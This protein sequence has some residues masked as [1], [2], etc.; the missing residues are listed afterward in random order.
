METLRR[1]KSARPKA[2]GKMV[3]N[4]RAIGQ[5]LKAEEP[6]SRIQ[7]PFSDLYGGR[8]AIIS[9]PYSP[10][11]LA[12]M[13]EVSD[14][15][16]QCISAMSTN[17]DGFGYELVKPEFLKEEAV[18]EAEAEEEKKRLEG[19]FDYCNPGENFTIL[20]QKL[21]VDLEA[22]GNGYIEVVRNRGGEVSE[23]Y[24]LP[25]YTVRMTQ[26]DKDWTPFTQRVMDSET[27]QYEEVK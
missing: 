8:D 23:L 6:V 12:Q 18:N 20:R 19:L 1:K 10:L 16:Q 11:Q 17:I 2:E 15:L 13:V 26:I 25:A 24:L 22:T 5:I 14:I 3:L 7:D 21:R 4:V 9:P 27:G